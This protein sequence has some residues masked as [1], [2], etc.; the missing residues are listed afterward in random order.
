ME[1]ALSVSNAKCRACP[2]IC[3][4]AKEH[5]ALGAAINQLFDL[6][7]GSG[8]P[9]EAFV[10][11][12]QVYGDQI[13]EETAA[14]LADASVTDELSSFMRRAVD[15]PVDQLI[16]RRHAINVQADELAN[17]CE[18]TLSLRAKD[19]SGRTITV[20]VCAS[21]AAPSGNATE[22]ARINRS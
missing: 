2:A 3:G 15:V 9:D 6:G 17:D 18:G 14:Q 8:L 20:T 19:R 21:P 1:E 7:T 11:I 10:M 22:Q 12:R 4:M 5:A 16:Q 13:A